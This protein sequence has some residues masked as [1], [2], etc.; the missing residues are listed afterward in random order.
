MHT[1]TDQETDTDAREIEPV[2]PMLYVDIY[3]TGV[4]ATL[5]FEDALSDGGDGRIVALLYG[6]EG[7]CEIPI[8][9]ADFWGPGDAGSIGVITG[10][11]RVTRAGGKGMMR[12]G[13]EMERKGTYR[14]SMGMRI[15]WL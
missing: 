6:F 3:V 4:A 9:L 15:F 2:K 11:G 7:L 8:I 14:R 12:K 1:L 5:P 10:T 13:D